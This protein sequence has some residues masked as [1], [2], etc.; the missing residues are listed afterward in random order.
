MSSNG[1]GVLVIGFDDPNWE[2]KPYRALVAYGLSQ[3]ADLLFTAEVQRRLAASCSSVIATQRTSA[4]LLRTC[5][6]PMVATGRGTSSR[7]R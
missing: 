2:R 5:L 3:L 1:R 7:A 4:G 6:G